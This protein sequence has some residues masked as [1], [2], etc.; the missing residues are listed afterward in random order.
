MR[1][2]RGSTLAV[3]IFVVGLSGAPAAHADVPATCPGPDDPALGPVTTTTGSFNASMEGSYVQIP[4][5]VP[6]GSTGLR[7]RYCFDQPDFPAPNGLNNNTLDLSIYEPLSTGNTTHGPA[8]LRGSSGSAIRDVTVAVNGFTSEATYEAAPKGYV[9]G[10]T[11]RA[12]EPGSVPGGEWIA[13]L[14]LAAIS[15]SSEGNSDSEVDWRVD[16][17]T[18]TSPTF[19]DDPH[20]PAAYDSSAVRSSPGWYAGDFHVH[21]EHEPGNALMRETLDY[22]F[23]P[24]ADG[25]AGL[26]FVQLVDHNNTVAYGEIGKLQGEYPG[27]LI[28]RGTE[29]TTY[30]GHT[31]SLAGSGPVDYRTAPILRREA[32]GAFTPVR[33]ARP[34]SEIFDQV[35]SNGGF[36]QI[37]HPTIFPSQVPLLSTFCRG[38]PWDYTLDRD[39]L[40]KG[41]CDRGADGAARPRSAA[42]PRPKPVYAARR[43]FLG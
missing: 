2:L 35:H 27:F 43:P 3:A 12:Y 23:L 39:R 16:V 21:G 42:S 15:N 31:N 7:V 28:S 20:A 18:T 37:N 41:G 13:E 29:V 17:Q 5:D 33:A 40:Q 25:G 9:S 6:A 32:S 10:K 19:A 34:P 22:A 8:E 38:C 30:R 24:T 1:A 11:T 26:D 14:G 36:T 4:F